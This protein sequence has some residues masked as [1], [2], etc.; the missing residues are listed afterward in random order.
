M[1]RLD[2]AGLYEIASDAP[3]L[4]RPVLVQALDGFVD[5]GSA[6]SLARTHL[7]DHLPSQ[8]VATFDHDQLHDYRARRPPMLFVEDHWESYEEPRLALH[9]VH[10]ETGVPFLLLAGPEPDAQWERFTAAVQQLV[11]HFGV[12]LTVGL[13]AIPMALPHTRPVGVIAHSNDKELI[14]GYEPWIGTVQVPASAGHLLEHRLSQ[15]GHA[16]AGFAVHV[17][18]YVAQAEFPAASVVLLRE[19]GALTGLT[20]PLAELEAAALRTREAIDAQVEGSPDV[21]AVVSALEKQ[22][23]AFLSGRGS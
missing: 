5:A 7:L 18:Q 9:L 23:D 17:P 4:D 19:V 2:P 8:V 11:E 14:A 3:A 10:D 15:A 21:A 13:N 16:S 1:D 12:R 6:T 22:Y 20:L